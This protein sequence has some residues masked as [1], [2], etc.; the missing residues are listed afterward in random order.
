MPF[1]PKY[2]ITLHIRTN[3]LVGIGEL[4]LWTLKIK[5]EGKKAIFFFFSM[6]PLSS[7]FDVKFR[8]I[9]IRVERFTKLLPPV[10]DFGPLK[11]LTDTANRTTSDLQDETFLLMLHDFEYADLKTTQKERKSQNLN[12]LNRWNLQPGLNFTE[13]SGIPTFKDWHGD[14]GSL[15][16]KQ[17]MY[18]TFLRSS[19]L[20]VY[21]NNHTLVLSVRLFLQNWLRCRKI[22]LT[23]Y[24]LCPWNFGDKYLNSKIQMKFL[25]MWLNSWKRLQAAC[26][27]VPALSWNT[28][29][30]ALELIS[31]CKSGLCWWS[32][33]PVNGCAG[34]GWDHGPWSQT[35]WVQDHFCHV[36]PVR[37]YNKLCKS[38]NLTFFFCKV[39]LRTSSS[40]CSSKDTN[41]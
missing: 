25:A 40:W 19:Y 30:G 11:G 38:L 14:N 13:Y 18:F 33:L 9:W 22:M 4:L 8:R 2:L 34:A 21:L 20:R 31:V 26:C 12:R 3:W 23:N 17:F 24:L 16:Q 41:E 32:D 15:F 7:L 27:K 5:C 6:S 10:N 1:T 36:L 29:R 35:P 39:G 28:H 37:L